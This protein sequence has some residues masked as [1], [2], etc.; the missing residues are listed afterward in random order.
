M[1][2]RGLRPAG[3]GTAQGTQERT[4]NDDRDDDDQAAVVTIGADVGTPPREPPRR[5]PMI[6]PPSG[7]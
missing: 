6:G 2:A 1:A 7:A 3:L 4:V 5:W